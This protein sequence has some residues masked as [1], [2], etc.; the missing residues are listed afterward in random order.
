[1]V[2]LSNT[3]SQFQ[4]DMDVTNKEWYLHVGTMVIWVAKGPL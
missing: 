3:V 1:M 4:N 2:K